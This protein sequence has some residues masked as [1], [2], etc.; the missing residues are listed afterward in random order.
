MRHSRATGYRELPVPECFRF[1]SVAG[2][3]VLPVT[4]KSAVPILNGKKPA[5]NPVLTPGSLVTENY[6]LWSAADSGVLLVAEKSAVPIFTGKKPASTP[7]LTAGSPVTEISRQQRIDGDKLVGQEVS[8]I[9]FFNQPVTEPTNRV[10]AYT[11]FSD[12]CFTRTR[13]TGE[14][15]RYRPLLPQFFGY[16]A[17]SQKTL[18]TERHQPPGLTSYRDWWLQRKAAEPPLDRKKAASYEPIPA[19]K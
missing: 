5:S 1:P 16:R 12:S 14:V 17:F 18:V 6:R 3:G 13:D 2:P 15:T 7:V 19:K 11:T 9:N 8:S 10:L 4:E